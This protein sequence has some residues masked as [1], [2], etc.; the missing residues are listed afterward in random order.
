MVNWTIDSLKLFGGLTLGYGAFCA[1]V[2]GCVSGPVGALIGGA[3]GLI[4]GG[5][6]LFGEG[7][8]LTI[9]VVLRNK[10]KYNIS[11]Y[12]TLFRDFEKERL[13][14]L[15]KERIEKVKKLMEEYEKQLKEKN[16][17]C[18]G[19]YNIVKNNSYIKITLLKYIHLN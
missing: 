11:M 7:L 1:G 4:V 18:I 15:E 14:Q 13:D 16:I 3:V 8:I 2:V 19:L 5:T 10:I 17:Q 9:I 6:L 12:E